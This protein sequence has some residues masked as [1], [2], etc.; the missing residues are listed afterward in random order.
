MLNSKE[1]VQKNRCLHTHDNLQCILMAIILLFIFLFF[2]RNFLADLSCSMLGT[3]RRCS[4]RVS[5]A[6]NRWSDNAPELSLHVGRSKQG[7][8]QD[9]LWPVQYPTLVI[10]NT[11]YQDN[12]Q[13][14]TESLSRNS[15]NSSR[16]VKIAE[17]HKSLKAAEATIVP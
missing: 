11:T 2:Y 3:R 17:K 5:E 9:I 14:A 1:H 16:C 8:L 10:F 15:E 13:R 4:S 12:V 6:G 7:N